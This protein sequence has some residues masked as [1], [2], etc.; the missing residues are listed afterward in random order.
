MEKLFAFIG[1]IS[2]LA[3]SFFVVAWILSKIRN[4]PSSNVKKAGIALLICLVSSV[5]M[6]LTNTQNQSAESSTKSEQGQ[7]RE[8]TSEKEKADGIIGKNPGI[9]DLVT[10][11]EKEHKIS[12]DNGLTKTYDNDH[13]NAVIVD[14]R[15]INLTIT[16]TEGHKMDAIISSLVP[17]DGTEI[18]ATVD[19]SDPLLSKHI[20]IGHSD[21]LSIAIPS[22]KGNYTR[23]DLYDTPTGNYLSTVLDVGD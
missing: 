10:E 7:E 1:G 3:A 15:I 5:G 6:G 17:S 13:F 16:A 22:S 12:H 8:N 23:I 18:S 2:F 14:G 11:F 20:S 21:M 4:K 19:S 9:G